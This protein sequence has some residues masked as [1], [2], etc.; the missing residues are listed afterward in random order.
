MSLRIK[1][2]LWFAIP[3]VITA[4]AL[5]A[6]SIPGLEE[7][8]QEVGSAT[9]TEPIIALIIFAG[10]GGAIVGGVFYA[11]RHLMGR[12]ENGTVR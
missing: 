2:T 11:I 4:G 9:L 3:A 1:N 7:I 5:A 12:K 10:A 8:R 6:I